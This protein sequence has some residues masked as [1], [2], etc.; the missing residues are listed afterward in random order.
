MRQFEK[1]LK[2]LKTE[3]NHSVIET[4]QQGYKTLFEA[5]GENE[6]F[7]FINVVYDVNKAWKYIQ[8]NNVRKANIPV[9]GVASIWEHG[10]VSI[11][12]EYAEQLKPEDLK[13]PGIFLM[14][15][16]FSKIMPAKKMLIDG[17]HRAWKLH[18]LGEESMEVYVIDDPEVIES[19]VISPKAENAPL[20]EN[21]ELSYEDK[22]DLITEKL[23]N[24]KYNYDGEDYIVAFEFK[25]NSTHGNYI[26]IRFKYINNIELF[27]F[28]IS[29]KVERELEK[30]SRIFK[31]FSKH[32]GI[33][34]EYHQPFDIELSAP[35]DS[36][37]AGMATYVFFDNLYKK[38]VEE[39]W[40]SFKKVLDK[41][42]FVF[43]TVLEE[44]SEIL[45]E[46]SH[47][48]PMIAPILK[49]R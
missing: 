42:F 40:N 14:S 33:E 48:A 32:H 1:F 6:T 18:Q 27:D 31:R 28:M 49:L 29:E 23:S 35:D 25:S 16:T 24:Y 19:I 15:D 43:F 11:D 4:V 2:Q 3:Q 30:A 34:Q 39:W 45:E 41:F 9:E 22:L 26:S 13:N 8:E 36:I 47:I 10:I 12:K 20:V 37:Y 38:T 5:V 44:I 21:A 17:W 7:T 46:N